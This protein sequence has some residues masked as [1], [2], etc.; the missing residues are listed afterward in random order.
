M[1][2]LSVLG[3]VCHSC[4]HAVRVTIRKRTDAARANVRIRPL[5]GDKQ[6]LVRD[7]LALDGTGNPPNC[8]RIISSNAKQDRARAVGDAHWLP[9]DWICGIPDGTA[10]GTALGD[11][12]RASGAPAIGETIRDVF[13]RPIAKHWIFTPLITER[14]HGTECSSGSDEPAPVAPTAMFP[15]E[16]LENVSCTIARASLTDCSSSKRTK[17]GP[18]EIVIACRHD[19]WVCLGII[20]HRMFL[21][22][23]GCDLEEIRDRNVC[24]H[25]HGSVSAGLVFDRGMQA[26]QKRRC[27]R[28]AREAAHDF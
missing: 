6:T 20:D 26:H 14:C 18:S 5:V 3:I 16:L 24:L 28:V 8:F 25:R 19:P 12:Y 17:F 1:S 27:L 4:A 2:A 11:G 15:P 7:G 13:E 9:C 23:F 22:D 10:V 21:N